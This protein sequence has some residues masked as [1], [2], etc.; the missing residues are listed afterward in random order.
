M[1]TVREDGQNNIATPRRRLS[2]RVKTAMRGEE[3]DDQHKSKR[4]KRA[5]ITNSSDESANENRSGNMN[6]Y[7][8]KDLPS[9]LE[10]EIKSDAVDE[11]DEL[12]E[13]AGAKQ[14]KAKKSSQ[15]ARSSQAKQLE[16]ATI[17]AEK[18]GDKHKA[19]RKEGVIAIESDDESADGE[20][21]STSHTKSNNDKWKIVLSPLPEIKEW[22]KERQRRAE[23]TIDSVTDIFKTLENST[24]TTMQSTS[25]CISPFKEAQSLFHENREKLRIAHKV[26]QSEIKELLKNSVQ[27]LMD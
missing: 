24:A 10:R 26:A 11:L 15:Q 20:P 19:K 25:S 4:K 14:E 6:P 5:L 17:A 23:K 3:K 12:D 8:S 13:L 21:K 27:D 18:T 7:R 16:K 9:S 22:R 2:R 1:A